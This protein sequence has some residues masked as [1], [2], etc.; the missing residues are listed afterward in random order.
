MNTQSVNVGSDYQL[1][2]FNV[3]FHLLNNFDEL[4]KFKRVSRTSM[5]LNLME[6]FV[7]NET[8]QLKEDD[9]LNHFIRD[10]KLRN[11]DP[12]VPSFNKKKSQSFGRWEDSYLDDDL[13]TTPTIDDWRDG[14]SW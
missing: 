3:P 14:I 4:R 1:V 10:V 7:R 5:M 9:Q 12:K 11:S 6:K 13:P 8:K 2:T